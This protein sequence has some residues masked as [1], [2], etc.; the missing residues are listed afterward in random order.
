[1]IRLA[2]CEPQGT[3]RAC[4]ASHQDPAA[5]PPS[6]DSEMKS[7]PRLRIRR[8]HIERRVAARSQKKIADFPHRAR[9]A[10]ATA[11]PM[12]ERGHTVGRQCIQVRRHV[13]IERARRSEPGFVVDESAAAAIVRICELLDGLPLALELAAAWASTLSM[14]ELVGR[15]SE[16]MA[17]LN[18]DAHDPGRHRTS[19]PTRRLNSA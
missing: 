16:S 3:G 13:F 14:T 4:S 18:A 9:A 1:M 2:A 8:T 5:K 19:P 15:L 17:L 11:H 10:F 6:N 7:V 12:R